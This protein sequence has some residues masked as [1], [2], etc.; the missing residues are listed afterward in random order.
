MLSFF[1][2]KT[3]KGWRVIFLRSMHAYK[4]CIY[5]DTGRVVLIKMNTAGKYIKIMAGR[6]EEV[7]RQVSHDVEFQKQQ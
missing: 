3:G 6:K 7:H 2:Q 1:A 5:K 4:A